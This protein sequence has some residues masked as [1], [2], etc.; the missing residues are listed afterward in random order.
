MKRLHDIL[1]AETRPHIILAHVRKQQDDIEEI[2][3]VAPGLE[4]NFRAASAE[5]LEELAICYRFTLVLTG[6]PQ[7]YG[8]KLN[9]TRRQRGLENYSSESCVPGQFGVLLANR[10]RFPTKGIV[11]EYNNIVIW[12]GSTE[13]AA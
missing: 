5:M 11:S 10:V 6:F 8:P 13:V 12:E 2:L 3:R 4:P 7:N 1:A 9:A